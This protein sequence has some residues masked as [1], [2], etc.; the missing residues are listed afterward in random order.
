MKPIKYL[1]L[2]ALFL[3]GLWLAGCKKD[4]PEPKHSIVGIWECRGCNKDVY[5]FP[6]NGIISSEEDANGRVTTEK[7]RI[8]AGGDSLQFIRIVFYPA[9]NRPTESYGI[10]IGTYRIHFHTND[11]ILVENFG[12]WCTTPNAEG[13]CDATLTR[14]KCI[15]N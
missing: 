5:I 4:E 14:I 10:T 2:I 7:Y 3:G 13:K 15:T 1:P 8:I 9:P 6:K 11:T 12:T